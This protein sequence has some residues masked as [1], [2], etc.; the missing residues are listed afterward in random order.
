[1]LGVMAVALTSAALAQSTESTPHDEGVDV[2]DPPHP[3]AP[4]VDVVDGE[5]TLRW[6]PLAGATYHLEL[7]YQLGYI[8]RT[9]AE[10]PLEGVA[11]TWQ[12]TLPPQ[13]WLQHPVAGAPPLTAEE[14]AFPGVVR[15]DLIEE[16]P[17]AW[18]VSLGGVI[19]EVHHPSGTSQAAEHRPVFSY[20]GSR[21][22]TPALVLHT[23]GIL[24]LPDSVD[25]PDR[26]WGAPAGDALDEEAH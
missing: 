25:S 23:E 14:R 16:A 20:R 4:Q 2:S 26:P 22:V 24:P 6:E 12:V 21:E 5:A 1:S 7:T 13:G 17:G 15:A 10:G 18:P 3:R 11:G 8:V 19:L 9:W